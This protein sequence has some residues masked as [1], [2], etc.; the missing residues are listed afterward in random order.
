MF[1]VYIL[2]SE[3]LSKY[4][5]DQTNNLEDRIKRH[6]SGRNKYTAQGIPWTVV[7]SFKVGSRIDAGNFGI[8]NK[9][10]RYF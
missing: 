8:K 9:E 7:K 10:K 2:Y 5:C 4:Y 6:N 1:Y 3:W